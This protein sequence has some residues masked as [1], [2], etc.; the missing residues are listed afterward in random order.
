LKG[1]LKGIGR[2]ERSRMTEVPDKYFN[3]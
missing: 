3:Q 2:H 1:R